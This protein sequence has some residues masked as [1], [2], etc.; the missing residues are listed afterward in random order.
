MTGE[1]FSEFVGG[2]NTERIGQEKILSIGN[3]RNFN[4][5]HQFLQVVAEAKSEDKLAL[6][7][8]LKEIG[9]IVGYVGSDI[10]DSPSLNQA[11]VGFSLGI[12]GSDIAKEASSVILLDDS[13]NSVLNGIKWG[14]NIYES[15]R[16]YIQFQ[17]TIVFSV[18]I[19]VF[20]STLTT[21][22][23]IFTPVQLIWV[24]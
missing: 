18:L 24:R 22:E 7:T 8:G 23:S 1:E 16:K 20:I 12:N 10:S 4:K 6:V 11:E 3:S 21:R 5:I 19:L 15:L 13:F 2:Y 14:R 9:N 17:F